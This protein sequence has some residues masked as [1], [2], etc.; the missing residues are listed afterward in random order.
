MQFIIY[1]I[2]IILF[3]IYWFILYFFHILLPVYSS[4]NE[5]AAPSDSG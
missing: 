3:I 5:S 2:Y 4:V 1:T